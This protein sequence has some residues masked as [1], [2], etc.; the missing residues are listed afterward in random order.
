MS[1]HYKKN[2]RF[3]LLLLIMVEH[4][5]ATNYG[6]QIQSTI[7]AIYVSTMQSNISDSSPQSDLHKFNLH[8]GRL[9][10]PQM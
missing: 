8:I 7:Y 4:L 5:G 6:L 2:L 10:V 3:T 9:K 1:D